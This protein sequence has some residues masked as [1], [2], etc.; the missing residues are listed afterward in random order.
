MNAL[1]LAQTELDLIRAVF[2]NADSGSAGLSSAIK[3][4]AALVVRSAIQA[5]L[6]GSTIGEVH[7]ARFDELSEPAASSTAASQTGGQGDRGPSHNAT[8]EQRPPYPARRLEI[9]R[10]SRNPETHALPW[11]VGLE[12]LLAHDLPHSRQLH[13]PMFGF[14]AHCICVFHHGYRWRSRCGLGWRPNRQR[15]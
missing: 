9:Q 4:G 14:D 2:S 5:I 11:A 8:Q 1:G 7:A 6:S 15:P 13:D 12:W 3:E 10:S